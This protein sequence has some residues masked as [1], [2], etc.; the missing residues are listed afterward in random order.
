VTVDGTRLQRHLDQLRRGR[1]AAHVDRIGE[2]DP[3]IRR[4]IAAVVAA[5]ERS[6]P[7]PVWRG[8]GA[9]DPASLAMRLA[10]GLDADAVETP[11]ALSL[12]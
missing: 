7:Q 1:A 12:S 9:A 11:R 5:G 3:E 6:T 10:Q 8:A 2:A 4:V